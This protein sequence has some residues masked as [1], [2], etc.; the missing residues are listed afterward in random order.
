MSD[1]RIIPVTTKKGLRTFIQ[2]YYDLYEGSKYAVPYL[3]FDEWNTLSKD[4]NPAFDFCEA[5]YFLAIDY[6]IPKVVGRIAAI[7]NHCAN[8]QWNKKQVRF[9]WFDFIDNLEVSSKLLDAAARWGRE[10]GMEELVGPLGFTDMDREGMLI[11][12][13][14]EKSTMYVNYN[15][16]YYPKHM[17]A[18]DH[19]QKDNDWLEYRIKVP[20]VTP[21]KFAKTAQLIESRYNLHVHKFTKHELVQGGMGREVFRIV[22]ETY[23]DL[24]DFQQLTDRQIDGY[25]DSYIKMADMNLITGVVDGNDNNRLI[26]FGVSFPSMTEALQKNRNGKLFP[27]GWLRLL[28]VMKCH[29]H[30][31][32]GFGAHRRASGI[33]QQGCQCPH[34]RRPHR[35]VPPLRFQMG[36]GDAADGEQQGCAEPVAVSGKRAAPSPPLLQKKVIG[37]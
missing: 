13:F 34:L 24:Y 28:R 5:Q 20:E 6:S 35:A 8:D 2:F 12:G 32:R 18:L 25:V 3:R 16:P 31:Y 22:N 15:Y 26:G 29:G 4:K 27:W 11:E 19:F 7:I 23:K 33:P 1:I 30:R 17:D 9:G 36:G 21:P 14:H 10:H 37:I